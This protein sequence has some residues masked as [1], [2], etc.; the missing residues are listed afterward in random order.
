MSNKNTDFDILMEHGIDIRGRIIYLQGDVDEAVIHSR[1]KLLRYLDK[2]TGEI[3]VVLDS[4]G[5]DVNLGFS[6]YDE[7]KDCRN[8]VTVRVSGVAMSMGSVI[9]QAADKRIITKHSRMMIH[10][11]SMEIEGHFTDVKRAVAENDEMD[12]ICVDIYLDKIKEV[13]PEFKKTQVQK[14]MEHDTYISAD[15][16]LEL[17]LVDEIEGDESEEG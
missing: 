5:G 2:T 6:F 8:E 17:G 11:G 14:M 12:K 9:L 1:I 16:A 7:I 13:K 10:K 4:G 15:K 3:T